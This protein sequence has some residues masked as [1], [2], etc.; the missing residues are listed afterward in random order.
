MKI[1][2]ERKL[3]ISYWNLMS[4]SERKSLCL[5]IMLVLGILGIV[6]IFVGVARYTSFI[7][8]LMMYLLG[9]CMTSVALFIA[10]YLDTI[11]HYER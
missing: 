10:I 9:G 1:T 8:S 11:S 4:V 6:A 2:V 7:F 5:N 3:E